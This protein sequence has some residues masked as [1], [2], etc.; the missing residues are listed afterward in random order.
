MGFSESGFEFVSVWRRAAAFLVD[1]FLLFIFCGLIFFGGLSSSNMLIAVLFLLICT[2]IF[3]GYFIFF[4]GPL[5]GSTPGKQLL[6]II[7]VD[8]NNLQPISYQK[9]IIRNILRIIDLFPYIIPG[10]IGL[11]AIITS[12]KK[13]RLGDKAAKT[14]VIKKK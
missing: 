14:I 5:S 1:L 3:F 11:I 2:I 7:V 6:S 13:Q 8:Q 4:E 10:L 12:K 9:S